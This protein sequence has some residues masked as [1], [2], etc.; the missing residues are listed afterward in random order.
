MQEKRTLTWTSSVD[1]WFAFLLAFLLLVSLGVAPWSLAA[2]ERSYQALLSWLEEYRDATPA[3]QPGRHLTTADQ[4]AL[5][6]FVPLPAR[7]FY[8]YPEMDMEIAPTGHYP[9]PEG[10]GASVVPGY[11]LQEDGALVGFTGGGFPFPV[12]EPDDPQAA[13]KVLW[14]MLWRP[15][16]Y[17]N[18]MPMVAWSR[19]VGGKLDREIDLVSTSAEFARGDH[20]LVPGQEEV[21]G[22]SLTEFRAPRDMAGTKT[23]TTTYVDPYKEDDGWLYI[24]AQRKPRRQL[25]SERTSETPGMDNIPEDGMGFSGKVYEH[26][27]KY[28]GKKTVLATINLA[29]HPEAGGPHKWVPHKARWELRECHVIEQIPKNPNHPYSHKLLFIDS[30]TFWTTW[31]LAYDRTGQLLRMGQHFLKYSESYATEEAMQAPYVK[32]DYSQNAGQ[33]VFLHVGEADINVQKPHATFFHCYVAHRD[34][35]SGWAK[36]FYSLRNMVNGRR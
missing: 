21:R 9:P 6:P 20:C 12:I 14:N 25:S 35:T 32:V 33:N 30:E 13:V 18:L 3:F 1:R 16:A 23:L 36:Q 7:E 34:F 29:T 15:G 5:T 17:N 10:W 4:D 8:F 31:M 2:E 24:P 26:T 11:A 27:W 22:K 19:G 28:L